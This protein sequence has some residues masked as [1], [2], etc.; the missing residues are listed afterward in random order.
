MPPD[1]LKGDIVLLR[2]TII[3]LSFLFL[4]V[5]ATSCSNGISNPVEPSEPMGNAPTAQADYSQCVLWGMWDIYFDEDEMSFGVIPVRETGFHADV[6]SMVT[7]PACM[8]CIT[9]TPKGFNP[10]TR[11]LNVDITLRNP[12]PINGYDVRGILFTDASGHLLMNADGWTDLYDQPGG[13]DINPFKAFAKGVIKRQFAGL[14]QNTENYLVYIPIPS[15]YA[16][17][18]YAVDASWP[19]NCKEPYSISNFSQDVITSEVG[20]SGMVRVTVEDWQTDVSSV[21]LY[22]Q[23]INGQE[24][25]EMSP[26]PGNSW[27]IEL[28]NSQGA[29]PGDWQVTFEASSTNSGTQ[30]LHKVEFVTISGG[31]SNGWARTWGGEGFD[32]GNSVATD[33]DG[34]V[35][36][37][38]HYYETVD[39]D[40]GTG[41]DEHTSNGK[42]DAYIVKYDPN[43]NF[44]WVKTWGG[45]DYDT[46]SDFLISA[47][48]EIY[49][50]GFFNSTVDF[51]PG[52][53]TVEH[54]SAGKSDCYLSKFNSNGDFLWVV[55]WGG[56]GS[57]M[58]MEISTD[59]SGNL[60]FAGD[61]T[62][63]CD[64][65]PGPGT[66]EHASNGD[67]D[68]FISK[69][70]ADGNFQWAVT[71]GG[72]GYDSPVA[73]D[74]VF[75][76]TIYVSGSFEGTT[77][78]DPGP[79][80]DEHTAGGW[81]DSFLVKYNQ[82]GTYQWS[83]TWGGDE[84]T[85]TADISSDS[86]GNAVILGYFS[87]TVD[88]DPGAG[89]EEH[90]SQGV[91]D[92]YLTQIN[93]SGV[94]QWV[95]I[96]GGVNFDTGQAITRDMSGNIYAVGCF[97]Y[98]VDFD[99]GP[100][101]DEHTSNA[102]MDIYV[103]KFN[104]SGDFIWARTF[105]G[106]Q[107]DCPEGVASDTNSNALIIGYFNETVD[108]DPGPGV[109]EH[110]S[111]G[112][113]DVFVTKLP[114][115]GNW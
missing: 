54:T 66:D 76:D 39:F 112:S 96:W 48:G 36:C 90:T 41:V 30:A 4:I 45:S 58:P 106:S 98:T 55:A 49:L 111:N 44:T 114:P 27:E 50:T 81:V 19:G 9:I 86:L 103:S 28:V 33:T 92:V 101:V 21:R 47:T 29:A 100:G 74:T 61:F 73:I 20:S 31:P 38:G 59:V 88:F 56:A 110:T 15:N 78:F 70:D 17:I 80:S 64:F 14:S 32:E 65:D 24:Y 60:Y 115:D 79:G 11:I 85:S 18:R 23:D 52:P 109:D 1:Y 7:P 5:S 2:T 26:I 3:L 83:V 16:G 43:G 42:N 104:T 94:F 53:G 25:I 10:V 113:P 8:D 37:V 102:S 71:W 40:P 72:A 35:Y 82:N 62:G 105:G 68:V 77:D 12:S 34:N 93:S 46:V 91:T 95:K 84:E 69:L 6:T 75:A 63:T 97:S 67:W 89:T 22:A 99:P 13:L 57:D 107:G 108:F 87:S 51:D